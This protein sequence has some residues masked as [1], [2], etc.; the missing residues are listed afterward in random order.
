MDQLS[1][2]RY[3][4]TRLKQLGVQTV[5][6]VPGGAH[7]ILSIGFAGL[8]FLY[9][10][11]TTGLDYE[12]VILDMI[13]DS[14]LSWKGNPNELIAGYAVCYPSLICDRHFTQ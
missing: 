3:I 14:G 2:G 1:I 4:F 9:A 12:L 13:P 8:Q 5:F 11:L 10:N 7:I 6:G